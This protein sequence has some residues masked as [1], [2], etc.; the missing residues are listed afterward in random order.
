M[1]RLAVVSFIVLATR[2]FSAG[3][4]SVKCL[5]GAER[6]RKV[7]VS[8]WSSA[9]ARLEERAGLRSPAGAQ[10]VVCSSRRQFREAAATA[11]RWAAAVTV[12][13]RR[14]IIIDGS[15]LLRARGGP[16]ALLAHEMLHLALAGAAGGEAGLFPLWFNEGLACWTADAPHPGDFDRVD[17][18]ASLNGLPRL[19]Q[20]A[21]AFPSDSRKAALAYLT[22]EHFVRYLAS[23]FGPLALRRIVA[24]TL[25]E[26]SFEKAFERVCGRPVEVAEL[27]WLERLRK[28]DPTVWVVLRHIDGF[29]L[30]ALLAIAAFVAMRIRNRRIRERWDREGFG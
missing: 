22:S 7:I 20:I 6:L 1:C 16:R 4:V 30:M 3:E 11:P 8:E 19:S 26:H 28:Q 15:S 9:A 21:D 23:R 29:A 27:E 2:A 25:A 14:T 17:F 5:P 24:Q 12:P 10:V 13:S 18:E